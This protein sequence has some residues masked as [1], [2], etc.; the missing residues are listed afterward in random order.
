MKA[1]KKIYCSLLVIS[2]GFSQFN[3]ENVG[4]SGS[5][6][7]VTI[8]GK[9]YNQIA[10]RPEIP[11][12]KLGIGLDLYFYL[13][14]DGNLY[15]ESWDFSSTKAG[16]RTILDKIYYIRWAKPGD[17]LYFRA[18]SLVYATLGQGILVNGY[19]N[20]L[21]YPQVRR[22]G[23]DLKAK[24][25]GFGIEYIQ[26]DF[27]RTPGVMGVRMSRGVMPKLDIGFSFVTDVD[28]NK[29]LG[30]R[31]DDGYPDVFD[32]FPDDENK[33][34]EAQENKEDWKEIWESSVDT[35]IYS[36][37]DWFASLPLNHNT[38]DPEEFEPDNVS[39][40][41]FDLSYQLNN[42]ITLYSQFA[43]L[44]GETTEH[45]DDFNNS[46]GL[47]FVPIG[48][49]GRFGPVDVRAEIR[50]S[51]RNF[52]FNYWDRSYDVNRIIYDGDSLITRESELY[53]YGNMQGIY[54]EISSNLFN[55]V[56]FGAGYQDL[57]GEQWDDGISDYIDDSNRSFLATLQLNT[58]IIPRLKT[59]KLFYQQNN[60]P[61][62]FKFDPSPSTIH[63]YDL[64][65]ELSGGMMLVYKSRT[66]YMDNG[67]GLEPVK[68][69][70]FETQILFK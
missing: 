12:G 16:Y 66:T 42:H 38:F 37:N 36:F 25:S 46:L 44:I 70:N 4:V 56:T 62:P 51:T 60:V 2:I 48:M 55:F 5:F 31:D 29:G 11:I 63:G 9:I 59:A 28:Q 58:S 15:K 53:R 43:Q 67:N 26:S 23:L 8:D 3:T 69:A 27:K 22:I 54:A 33:Y 61:N 18:G 45:G 52:V 21:E 13:D 32:H 41:S 35:N 64:G 17:P 50:K 24:V 68:S 39:G 7:S 20:V 47:G 65:V 49:S 19:S 40:Y 30:D 10:I 34:D 1:F 14:G 6:G 57:K